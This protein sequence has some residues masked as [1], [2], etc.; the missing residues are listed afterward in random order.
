MPAPTVYPTALFDKLDTFML[1]FMEHDKEIT[2][3]V[4]SYGEA[5]A[6]ADVWEW[7]NVRQTKPGPKTVLGTNPDG[8]EVWLS[9]Q[10]PFG[11]IK[12]HENDYWEILKIQLG[13]VKFKGT[14]AKEITEE[15]EDASLKAMKLIAQVVGDNAPIDKGDLSKSFKAVK[16]GDIL[17]DDDYDERT[18]Y[19][20]G[21]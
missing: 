3:G 19:V 4:A 14:T 15:L 10:A 20:G 18:L 1:E 17:L 8:E 21:E 9:I 5:A 16:P 6:Y 13:K 11:Y 7:G 12:I 2:A